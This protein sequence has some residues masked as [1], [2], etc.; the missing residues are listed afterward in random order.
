ML[1]KT[2]SFLI[3]IS[4]INF[5]FC[6]TVPSVTG[7]E[8]NVRISSQKEII[9]YKFPEIRLI[10]QSAKS[11]K[12]KIMRLNNSSV[13]FLP[14]PYWNKEILEIDLDD[15][16]SI[17]IKKTVSY[18]GRAAAGAFPTGFIFGGIVG[19]ASSQYDSDF[20]SWIL[21]SAII[22]GISALIGLLIGGAAEAATKKAF[23]MNEMS[24]SEKRE[25]IKKIIGQPY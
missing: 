9:A 23:R 7:N 2:L 10:V 8:R 14:Y 16:Y 5:I 3:L 17:T 6:Q 19:L 1:K 4:F 18:A 21:L 25:V 22:G 24:R 13:E 15:I 12:G 11:H 20:S